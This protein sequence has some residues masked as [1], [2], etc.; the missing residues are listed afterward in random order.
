MASR[1]C[2][3]NTTKE[4]ISKLFSEPTE[5][6]QQ[7]IMSNVQFQTWGS[8]YSLKIVLMVVMKLSNFHQLTLSE[9]YNVDVLKKHSPTNLSSMMIFPLEL[10]QKYLLLKNLFVN[11]PQLISPKNNIRPIFQANDATT[12]RTIPKIEPLEKCARI[13]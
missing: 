12:G 4:R 8:D 2:S 13:I 10:Y 6:L 11:K 3:R 5:R 1:F 9:Q 7:L